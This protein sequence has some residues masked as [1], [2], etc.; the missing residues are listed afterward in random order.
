VRGHAFYL[1]HQLRSRKPRRHF[2]E[3]M[4]M[5]RHPANGKY[6]TSQSLCL[7]YNA[8][9]YRAFCFAYQER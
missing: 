4:H 8:T 5:I 9:V 6:G 2:H 3:Q 7:R 1:M